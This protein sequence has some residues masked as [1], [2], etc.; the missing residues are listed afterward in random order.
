MAKEYEYRVSLTLNRNDPLHRTAIT[1]LEAQGRRKTQFVVNAV[2]HYIMEEKR[3]EEPYVPDRAY[4]E[5]IC[6]EVCQSILQQNPGFVQPATRPSS[7]EEAAECEP[8]ENLDF[9]TDVLNSFRKQT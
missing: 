6:R 8:E 3:R 5:K 9:V 4:I 7:E 1:A 2:A